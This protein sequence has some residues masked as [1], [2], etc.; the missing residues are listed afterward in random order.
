MLLVDKHAGLTSHDV[1]SRIRR[2]TGIRKVGHGGT[3]D[4]FATGLLLILLGKATRLFDYLAPL[5]KT[6][7]VTVQFGAVSSTG[8][9]D[10]EI[11]P[12]AGLVTESALQAAL[13]AFCGEIMQRPHRYSAVKVGGEAMYRRARRG[14]QIEAAPRKVTI[15]S[16]RLTGFESERQRAELEIRCSKGTYIRSLCE[17][18]GKV[19]NTGA[20]A[21]TL[22]RTQ[23]GDFM[24]DKAASLAGLEPLLKSA[25]VADLPSFI[26]CMGALYFLPV[27]ELDE[28]ERPS[29]LHGLTI[30]GASDGPVRVVSNGELIA[31]YGPAENGRLRPLAVLA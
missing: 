24:V 16:L 11:E 29:V 15:G 10:G 14:E 2:L 27:R 20:Y 18:L 26:S 19:L 30:S 5:E 6:Y 22:R 17:D 13:P 3:L 28:N 31:I 7:V 8:D 4:P 23:I 9:T 25:T 21:A 12:V 1:V